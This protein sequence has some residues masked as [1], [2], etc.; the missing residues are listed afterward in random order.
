[1]SSDAESSMAPS[2]AELKTDAEDVEPKRARLEE[3]ESDIQITIEDV[4]QMA[5]TV[6]SVATRSLCSPFN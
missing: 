1:M 3:Q 2:K 5:P 4:H 6:S